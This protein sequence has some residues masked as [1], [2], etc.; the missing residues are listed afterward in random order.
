M[1]IVILILIFTISAFLVGLAFWKENA[2]LLFI[3][4]LTLMLL[5]FI[6]FDGI[7]YTDGTIGLT[8]SWTENTVTTIWTGQPFADDCGETT[9]EYGMPGP[10]RLLLHMDELIGNDDYCTVEDS[11]CPNNHARR[12]KSDS[13]NYNEG[14]LTQQDGVWGYMYYFNYDDETI[15]NNGTLIVNG[16]CS[17]DYTP[18]NFTCD[19][20]GTI[21]LWWGS[22]ITAYPKAGVCGSDQAD[23]RGIMRLATLNKRMGNS[24]E[25][26]TEIMLLGVWCYESGEDTY[27]RLCSGMYGNGEAGNGYWQSLWCTDDYRPD[28]ELFKTV[29]PPALTD[30]KYY[31][32][33]TVGDDEIKLYVDGTPITYSAIIEE[34]SG[35]FWFSDLAYNSEP[36]DSEK[37]QF[38][39]S[40]TMSNIANQNFQ[41]IRNTAK[42]SSMDEIGIW[43]IEFN[44]NNASDAYSHQF[45]VTDSRE[46]T[47]ANSTASYLYVEERNIW[48]DGLALTLILLGLLLSINAALEVATQGSHKF[49]EES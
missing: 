34:I 24:K 21:G 7:R 12:D 29:F 4:G 42:F 2:I 23:P 33:R 31:M 6:L 46:S 20:Y 30:P 47:Y 5:G 35:S 41:G 48:T 3:G 13:G 11:S 36:C 45:S 37:F 8:E 32:V 22:D 28:D 49:L 18:A 10:D 9:G 19:D 39:I 44:D 43:S 16:S 40:G 1:D 38:Q 17:A 14:V 26:R 25:N 15:W 27:F